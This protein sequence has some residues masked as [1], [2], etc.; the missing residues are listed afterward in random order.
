MQAEIQRQIDLNAGT[1]R[2]VVLDFPLLGE[3]PRKGLAAT[4]VVD[5]PYELAVERVVEYRGMDEGDAQIGSTVRSV[6]KN[7]V[8]GRPMSSTTPAPSTALRLRWTSSGRQLSN[9]RMSR[10]RS[11]TRAEQFQL[12]EFS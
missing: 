6:A 9:S 11:P 12:S 3:N 2:V 8:R 1:D 7:V 10:R 4:I 5:V